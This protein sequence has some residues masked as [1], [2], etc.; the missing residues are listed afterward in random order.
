MLYFRPPSVTYLARGQQG[1][2]AIRAWS[3]E[4]FGVKPRISA[5]G[6]GLWQPRA[7]HAPNTPL[8]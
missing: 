7:S 5:C 1:H 3:N 6:P 2:L 4:I 8:N